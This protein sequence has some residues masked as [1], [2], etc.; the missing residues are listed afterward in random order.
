MRAAHGRGRGRRPPGAGCRRRRWAG[1]AVIVG[2]LDTRQGT[3]VFYRLSTL[4]PGQTITIERTDGS[5]ATFLIDDI[6]NYPK[7]AFP[8]DH[9]YQ[10][11]GR[12]ELRLITCAWPYDRTHG[13]YQDNTVIYAHLIEQRPQPAGPAEP[14]ASTG[15]R[16]R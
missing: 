9:V 8:T 15:G 5:T 4:S 11:T 10:T 12:P 2:H 1:S 16:R 3:A 6:Q 14:E 13:G 7:T